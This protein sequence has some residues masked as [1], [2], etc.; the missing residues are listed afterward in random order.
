MLLTLGT[1]DNTATAER[2]IHTC[3]GLV[4]AFQL[5]NELKA[6]ARSIVQ[7][8]AVVS[9]NGER[10]SVCRKGMI[11]N[12]M[13]KEVMNFWSS[14]CEVC[15]VIGVSL[16]YQLVCFFIG[17]EVQALP[18]RNDEYGGAAASRLVIKVSSSR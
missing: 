14:H 6:I 11:G 7:L 12:W 5:I 3:N 16:Y 15:I 10:L 4:V 8:N 18:Q 13:V 9:R 1:S 17:V 2:N